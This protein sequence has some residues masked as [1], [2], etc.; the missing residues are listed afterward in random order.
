MNINN[1]IAASRVSL[2]SVLCA[3]LAS[4]EPVPFDYHAE[5]SFVIADVSD[6]TLAQEVCEWTGAHEGLSGF[7]PLVEGLDAFGARLRLLDMAERSVDLQ[8][9]LMKDDEAGRL[10]AAALLRTADRG[11][12]V[13]FLLDDIFSTV[14]D[15]TLVLLDMHEN[16]EVRLYNP[17]ARGGIVY[18]NFLADF[19]R[20]NRRMHNKSFTVDNSVTIVG[21]R[22]IADE[23]FELRDDAEFLDFDIVGIGPVAADVG[24]AF[25][26]FWNHENSVPMAALERRHDT[27]EF[28]TW[29]SAVEADF[30]HAE[31]S[32]YARAKDSQIV[33]DLLHDRVS[34][35]PARYDVV[36]DDPVKLVSE[37]SHEHQAV[38]TYLADKA[39]KADSE[40]IFV[41]P[42]FVPLAYG[43][44][45]FQELAADGLRV[46][47]V[48][49]SL[50]SNNH[51]AVHSAYSRYRADILAAGVE[52]YEARA[53][54]VSQ[55]VG[56]ESR[57]AGQLTLHTKAIAIDRE[58]LFVGSLNLDPRSIDINSEMGILVY[59][60]PLTSA[61][62]AMFLE[63]LPEFAY[64][65]EMDSKGK[66]MWRGLIGG[67]EVIKRREP[68][69]SVWRRFKAWTLKVAPESQL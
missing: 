45:Y 35:Y 68:Q 16:I 63:D 42:Y 31:T 66:I 22:N 51:T 39:A 1:A 34:L 48:T 44:E 55:S 17:V 6:T 26:A 7:Y 33:N 52:L 5:Q 25:D 27:A 15:R 12:R 54:A 8:Y 67:K 61:L 41:S 36:M 62:A 30:D 32:V 20:A 11:V 59:S 53:D 47:V 57:E 56:D 58:A 29:R 23:Y 60:E 2:L 14:E 43:L 4:C 10:L 40:I 69:A 18:L 64:R 3:A 38:L 65:V 49:N 24:Q 21:G 37:V 9:F 50:A 28:S 19:K 13:R 46:V